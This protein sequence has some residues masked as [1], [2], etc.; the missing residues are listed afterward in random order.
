[1]AAPKKLYEPR[2]L[3]SL[4]TLTEATSSP[5]PLAYERT[6]LR[7]GTKRPMVLNRITADNFTASGFTSL[8]LRNARIRLGI[9]QKYLFSREP[10]PVALLR[11]RKTTQPWIPNSTGFPGFAYLRLDHPHIVP[12]SGSLDMHISASTA[13]NGRSFSVA[14]HERSAEDDAG[15]SFG[16]AGIV[17]APTATGA[18]PTITG[19]G[20]AGANTGDPAF[21]GGGTPSGT[22][23]VPAQGLVA[24]N[25]LAARTNRAGSS[26]VEGFSVGVSVTGSTAVD[27]REAGLSMRT[28]G[29][30]S[31]EWWW[32]PAAPLTLVMDSLTPSSSYE[33]PCP[34]TLE[35]GQ[36]LNL[37]VV[38]DNRQVGGINN[39]GVA[40]N[41]YSEIDG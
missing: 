36:Y 15:T 31:G 6:T 12:P 38:Y 7:N 10:M 21:G 24:A 23:P 2:A 8:S 29:Y 14:Y 25:F 1:M 41:G 20:T 5:V 22:D 18:L 33:L 27:L 26:L 30:G 37:E 13:L 11:Q 35:P 28:V 19:T 16:G 32:T 3:W 40:L 9:G 39:L 34:I 17:S 4:F